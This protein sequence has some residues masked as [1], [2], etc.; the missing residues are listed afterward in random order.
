MS[1]HYD[2]LIIQAEIDRRYELAGV[3]R[4]GTRKHNRYRHHQTNRP[5]LA[6]RLT[7]FLAGLM[8]TT[9]APRRPLARPGIPM[10]ADRP[11]QS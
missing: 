9:T 3:A 10:P 8:G 6:H 5:L 7:A 4:P 1:L 11:R 2:Q